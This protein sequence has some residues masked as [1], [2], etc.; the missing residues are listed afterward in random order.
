MQRAIS[1]TGGWTEEQ[2]D[3]GDGETERR[4]QLTDRVTSRAQLERLAKSNSLLDA[5]R[6]VVS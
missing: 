6:Q 4:T 3:G 1:P 2:M 5:F